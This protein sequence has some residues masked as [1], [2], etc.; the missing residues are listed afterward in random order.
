MAK[1]APPPDDT[2][3]D[4]AEP[5]TAR[6]LETMTNTINAAV[7]SQINRKIKPITDQLGVLPS[8]QETLEKLAAGTGAG[9]GTGQQPA[10]GQQQPAA[11]KIEEHPEFIAQ[12]KRLDA[13][14]AER[15][16][17]RSRA[18]AADRDARLTAI[19]STAGVDKNRLR[20]A[21]ALLREGVVFDKDGNPTMKAKRNGYEEDVD[22]ETGA[23][24]FFGTDE[25]KAYLAPTSPAPRGGSGSSART[26]AAGV[27]RGQ[28]GAGQSNAAAKGQSD[29]KVERKAAAA[30]ALMGAVGELIGGGNISVG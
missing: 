11:P 15:E 22:L 21:V 10:A 1:K 8:I 25:G 24:E 9:G 2:D 30:D 17:E 3:D 19:A 23:K 27:V 20:G 14:A 29:A 5:F 13:I 18:R 7:S 16:T 6:Q 4:D 26:S 28:G 12:R